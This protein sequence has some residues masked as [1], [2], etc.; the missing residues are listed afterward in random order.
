M[1][2]SDSPKKCTQ[3]VPIIH[4]VYQFRLN[5]TVSSEITRFRFILKNT[6]RVFVFICSGPWRAGGS[7]RCACLGSL[8]VV[9]LLLALLVWCPC[10]AFYFRKS[11]PR[12]SSYHENTDDFASL[13]WK[14]MPKSYFAKG[15][16]NEGQPVFYYN[17]K[18][19]GKDSN[20]GFDKA[21]GCLELLCLQ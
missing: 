10:F 5:Y 1:E 13:L 3:W 21:I 14:K 6:P 18:H 16:L 9:L 19:F 17:K 15:K 12:V 8:A 20:P 4:Y 11:A 7:P 2:A